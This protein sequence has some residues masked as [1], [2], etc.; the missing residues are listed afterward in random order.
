MNHQA[1]QE[2]QGHQEVS[3]EL[4]RIGRTVVDAGLKV[5]RLLGPGLLESTYEHCLAHEL[6]M[7][8][9][10]VQ[11]QVSLPIIYDGITLEGNYRLD[12]LVENKVII[13]VK[14][15]ETITRLHESQVLTYLKLSGRRLAFL[16]NFNVPLFKQGIRRFVV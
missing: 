2:H 4:D 11:R 12:L 6:G 7:R 8:L 15:V 1:H 13:E 14:A 10:S 9:S 16:I 5:H 3:A